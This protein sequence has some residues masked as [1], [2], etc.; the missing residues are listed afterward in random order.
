[1]R[2][3]VAFLLCSC[4]GT[5]S[6]AEPLR[7]AVASNFLMPAKAL[8]DRFEQA[9]GYQVSLS[10]GSTG[11]LYAQIVNGAPFSVFLA[12][13]AAEPRRLEAQGKV[14]A[15]SRFTYAV[16]R[17]VLWSRDPAQLAAGD[18]AD[19]IRNGEFARLAVANPKTAPYGMAALQAM[20]AL[21]LDP[22]TLGRRLVRGENV[23]Q[24]YQFTASGN[25]DLGFVALSQVSNPEKPAAGSYWL[26]PSDLHEPIEQQA[27][28]LDDS[29]NDE[30]ARLFF[31]FLK[32]PKSRELIARYGY[33]TP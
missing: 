9:S 13:N 31:D 26:V 1:M 22:A 24:V 21:G 25:A 14:V 15:G 3:L 17:L 20:Q 8:A 18:G 5:A 7:V 4:L 16:G 23:S 10:T 28:L 30:G 29:P 19:L 27:V 2:N 12:A 32:G 6:L 11:K 33:G